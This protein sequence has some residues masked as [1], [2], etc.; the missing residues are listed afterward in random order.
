MNF[1]TINSA[2]KELNKFENDCHELAEKVNLH[3]VSLTE[4]TFSPEEKNKTWQALLNYS[5]N[6]ISQ[7]ENVLGGLESVRF[8]QEES[9]LEE[10]KTNLIERFKILL[11]DLNKEKMTILRQIENKKI[12]LVS[13]RQKDLNEGYCYFCDTGIADRFSYRIEEKD[14][15]ILGVEINEKARFCSQE[16]LLSY[17]KEYKKREEVRQNEERKI[18]GNIE[19]NKKLVTEIQGKMTDLTDKLN[20]LERRERELELNFDDYAFSKKEEE[21]GFFKRLA[22]NLGLVKKSDNISPLEKARIKKIELKEQ[23]KKN[24]EELKKALVLL[25]ISKQVEEER[26]GTEKRLLQQKERISESE[27]EDI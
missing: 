17:C 24:E 9:V 10:E 26:R 2:Q 1:S 7:V 8:S 25:S 5:K 6:I 4:T 11:N 20:H 18:K 22:Q 14:K 3:L 12:F 27:Q 19:N 21:V 13:L 16:C 23:L 15:R